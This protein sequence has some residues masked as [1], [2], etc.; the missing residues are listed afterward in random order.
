MP[1]VPRR[2][3][4][5]LLVPAALLAFA[6]AVAPVARAAGPDD[7]TNAA[8]ALALYHEGVALLDAGKVEQALAKFRNSQALSPTAGALL[9]IADCHARLGKTATAWAEFLAAARL[10]RAQGKPVHEAEGQRRADVLQ[11]QLSYLTITATGAEPGL[12]IRRDGEPVRVLGEALPV[13][14]GQH[15]ITA[16]AP[17][18]QPWTITI[19]IGRESAREVARVPPLVRQVA[20][21]AAA[22]PPL[23]EP[24]PAPQLPPAGASQRG[25]WIVAGAGAVSLLAGGVFLALAIRA[26]DAA[27][28]LCKTPSSCP[29][30]NGLADAHRRDIDV[31]VAN[32][33][34]GVG[35]AT[36]GVATWLLWRGHR[37]EAAG[38]TPG[39][40]SF[41]VGATPH[42]LA[43]DVVVA[44]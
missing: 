7:A 10:A 33:A 2:V 38:R 31:T 13:D 30:D 12:E 34:I 18:R 37:R 40:A 14:P 23:T 15:E 20:P 25:P 39:V 28:T 32:V 8:E 3:R 29:D 16:T 35:V 1:F 11:P 17:G 6:V 24:R 9:N 36:V 5:A 43:A 44:F 26:N 42:Q 27:K 19:E 22:P 4:T 41:G 21:A